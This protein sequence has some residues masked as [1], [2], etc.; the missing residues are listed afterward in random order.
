MKTTLFLLSFLFLISCSTS[1]NE[2]FEDEENDNPILKNRNKSEILSYFNKLIENNQVIVGQHCGDGTNDIAN[3]Y[4]EYIE[5]LANETGKY[6][7]I[8]GAD[9]GF[10]PSTTYPVETLID[11]WNKGGLVTLSWHADNPFENGYDVYYNTV[12]NKDNIDLL[13][14][15]K[16]ANDN[17]AKT[18]YRNEL[19][20]IAKVLLK[21]KTSGVIVIFRPFHEMNGDFFWWGINDYNNQQT[22]ESDYVALW[23]DLYDT[24]TNDYGLDNLIWTYS[25]IPQANWSADVLAF[26]P[27]DDVV[28]IVGIDYYGINPDFP[29]Y[30]ALKSLGKTVV[31]SEAGPKDSGYGNWDEMELVNK[32]KGKAAYFLQWHSWSGAAVAIKDNLNAN[33]MMN[34]KEVITRDEL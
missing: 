25:P 8:V 28:D 34:S 16:S 23:K 20:A 5:T 26:Y 31:M 32:I 29:D 9:L 14:L 15:L 21:F 2:I 6:V 7:G 4:S 18:S 13:L 19:D 12:E 22:N 10:N 24:L 27:G 17:Q 11:H 30:D 1:S 33:M 3:F